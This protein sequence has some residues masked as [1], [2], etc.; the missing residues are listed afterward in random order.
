[1]DCKHKNTIAVYRR[2][3][4]TKG[5]PQNWIRIEDYRYCVDCKKIVKVKVEAQE[6]NGN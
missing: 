5:E 3:K 6:V 2:E 1:M 4:Y